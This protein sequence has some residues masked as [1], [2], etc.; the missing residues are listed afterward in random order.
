MIHKDERGS[1]TLWF[2][3][4]MP[5]LLIVLV[6]SFD[7]ARVY[8]AKIALKQSAALAARSAAIELDSFALAG[9]VKTDVDGNVVISSPEIVL[10][11]D[12]EKTFKYILDQNAK[13]YGSLFKDLNGSIWVINQNPEIAQY[14]WVSEAPWVVQAPNG[15]Q[16]EI[17]N[18][19]VVGL[20][21]ATVDLSPLARLALGKNQMDITVLTAASPE[22][23]P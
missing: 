7:L 22:L 4:F 10:N 16:V 6:L 11:N 1:A 9:L 14:Q 15:Y 8:A 23:R 17:N 12:T 3:Y 21:Q 20:V 18:T 2:V 19:S 5:A 13:S